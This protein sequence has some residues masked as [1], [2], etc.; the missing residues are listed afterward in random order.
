[1]KRQQQPVTVRKIAVR[2]DRKS[3]ERLVRAANE[4]GD[5]FQLHPLL[6]NL[7]EVNRLRSKLTQVPDVYVTAMTD[8]I[9]RRFNLDVADVWQ[10]LR[11]CACGRLFVALTRRA[12]YCTPE[13]SNRLRQKKFY[14][15]NTDE[16][17]KVKREHYRA[18]RDRRPKPRARDHPM[19]T[20]YLGK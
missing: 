12:N 6:C 9:A 1:M 17:R 4:M 8:M 19:K 13:C 5:V 18:I 2:I 15:R 3:L 16:Q 11:M 20:V 10:Q 14:D 7:A